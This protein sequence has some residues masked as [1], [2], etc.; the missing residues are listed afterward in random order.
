[1]IPFIYCSTNPEQKSLGEGICASFD[2]FVPV[3]MYDVVCME[4]DEG[5]DYLRKGLDKIKE[6]K[7]VVLYSQ[8]ISPILGAL[9]GRSVSVFGDEFLLRCDN[10]QPQFVNNNELAK[11]LKGRQGYRPPTTVIPFFSSD[12][13]PRDHYWRADSR[14]ETRVLVMGGG[15]AHTP[16]LSIFRGLE[17]TGH[18]F[19]LIINNPTDY[20]LHGNQLTNEE[21]KELLPEDSRITFISGYTPRAADIVICP[22]FRQTTTI[23]EALNSGALVLAQ[24]TRQSIDLRSRYGCLYDCDFGNPFMV[25]EAFRQIKDSTSLYDKLITGMASYGE[26]RTKDKIN[27]IYSALFGAKKRM[28]RVV[29]DSSV[30]NVFGLFRN[31]EKT[32]GKTL[33]GL[34]AMERRLSDYRFRY[35][36]YENDSDDDTPEQIRDFFTHSSGRFLCEKLGKK[37]WD[38]NSDPRRML[39][40]ASYRNKMIRLCNTWPQSTYSFIIDS[41]ISFPLTI[42]EDQITLL[43]SRKD[44]VMITP[45]G[46]PEHSSGYY[47]TYAFRG[48]K[49]EESPGL[50]DVPIEAKSAFSGFACILSSALQNCHWDCTGSESEH[51]HFCNM[52]TKYGKILIDPNMEV[53]WKK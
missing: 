9:E 49:G 36:F 42:M 40:L 46:M 12:Y 32:I 25:S 52:V 45:Y 15:F 6:D 50:I 14:M 37:H 20:A 31:N 33:A 22:I 24:T 1:M 13:A 47:D 4:P 27:D 38:G 51:I 7:V 39:D 26:M 5:E 17:A 41:E 44:A 43:Q 34:K 11:A 35:Y 29:G 19:R 53:R 3:P 18:N 23:H 48:M 10:N 21:I 8:S 2:G 16:Y 30:I 28:R